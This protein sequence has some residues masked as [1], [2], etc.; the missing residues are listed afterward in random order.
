MGMFMR[1][2]PIPSRPK[3][4]YL[5]G[6]MSNLPYFNFPAFME[7]EETLQS[8]GYEVFNPAK[9]DIERYGE[10]IANCPNGTHEEALI[11]VGQPVTYRDCLR[12][13]LNWIL[14]NADAI[15][16]LPGWEKSSGVKAEKALAECLKLE[17]I[18]L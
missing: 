5:A 1:A 14:D 7:A 9:K 17:E 6:P 13:D 3:R 18:Y 8:E 16:Y 2:R 11:N 15:A 4:V 12:V 10:G